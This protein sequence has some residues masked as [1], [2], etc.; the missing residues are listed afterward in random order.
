MKRYCTKV[1]KQN[2]WTE[3]FG[4]VPQQL[5][6]A[7]LGNRLIYLRAVRLGALIS[8]TSKIPNCWW[9]NCGCSELKHMILELIWW[10]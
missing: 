8:K 10:S 9:W 6:P 1:R 7:I 3:Q 4:M 2:R 5:K